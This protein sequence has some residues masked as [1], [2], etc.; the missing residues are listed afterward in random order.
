MGIYNALESDGKLGIGKQK[1]IDYVAP[2]ITLEE[3]RCRCCHKLPPDFD[4]TKKPYSELFEAFRILRSTFGKPIHISSGYRCPE[5]NKAIGGSLM[6]AHMF[7]TALDCD[8]IEV[9]EVNRLCRIMEL[10][11]P[12]FRRGEYTQG[13]T[14]I[15]IDNAFRIYPRGS[16]SWRKG[17]RWYG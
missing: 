17:V 14:F 16:K 15:H 12:H 3:Y 10:N 11:A 8:V 7:G 13:K 2:Y 6:S 4:A 5:H 9:S 1:M